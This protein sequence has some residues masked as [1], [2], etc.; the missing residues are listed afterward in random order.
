MEL[1]PEAAIRFSGFVRQINLA[2]HQTTTPD[3]E[4]LADS[5]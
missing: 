4:L 2:Q 5:H 1:Q 3:L